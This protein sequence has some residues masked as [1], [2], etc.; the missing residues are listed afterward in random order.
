MLDK[1]TIAVGALMALAGSQALSGAGSKA[2]GNGEIA[3]VEHSP[4]AF[5]TLYIRANADVKIHPGEAPRIVISAP[6]ASHERIELRTKRKELEIGVKGKEETFPRFSVDVYCPP[7]SGIG[8]AYAGTVDFADG[9]ASPVFM[10]GLAGAAEI[11]GTLNCDTVQINMAGSG[12]IRLTG[13]AGEAEINLVGDGTFAGKELRTAN[14]S[15]HIVGDGRI[16]IWTTGNLTTNIV[17]QG[18]ISYRGDP[19]MDVT[20]IGSGKFVRLPDN[21]PL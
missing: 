11:T 7:L 2:R 13:S 21:S 3:V 4:P 6:A 18:T 17:G 20:A 8:A 12:S 1:K 5:E 9:V 14:A 10:A 19:V 15:A 16:V